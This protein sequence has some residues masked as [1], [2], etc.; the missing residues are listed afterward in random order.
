MA[1]G[2]GVEELWWWWIEGRIGI[3]EVDRDRIVCFLCWFALV[4][5]VIVVDAVAGVEVELD[6]R[7]TCEESLYILVEEVLSE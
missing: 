2:I 5:V 4:D 3:V 1:R 6:V 7:L